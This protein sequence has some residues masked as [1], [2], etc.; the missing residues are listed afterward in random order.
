M[1]FATKTLDMEI[2]IMSFDGN[3]KHINFT[4]NSIKILH[5]DY[6]YFVLTPSVAQMTHFEHRIYRCK[7]TVTSLLNEGMKRSTKDWVYFVY[8]S[9]RLR[10][11][12]DEK[13]SKFITSDKDILFPVVD[14]VWNF[15][16]GSMNGIL[17]NRKFFEEV[18]PFIDENDLKITKLEWADRAINKG[19]K[20]KAIVNAINL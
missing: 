3:H 7:D 13:L 19:G 1:L 9:C 12:I 8:S 11:K 4:A 18:G 16:D 14:R 2:A 5:I 20:F 15:V 17:I 10:P 6:S